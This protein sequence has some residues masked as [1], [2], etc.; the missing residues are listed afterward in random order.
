MKNFR[1]YILTVII[2]CST[3]FF[4][5]AQELISLKRAVEIGLQNNY[6]IQ[7]ANNSQE[8]SSKNKEAAI[9]TLLPKIDATASLNKSTVDTRQVFVTG[10]IQERADA[11]ASQQNAGLQLSWVV[12][13]GLKI[14]AS[15]ELV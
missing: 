15:Y 7:I 12:F 6:S 11:K 14:F 3:P 13:D 10:V 1:I 4:T 5:E 9:S 2:A 8:I